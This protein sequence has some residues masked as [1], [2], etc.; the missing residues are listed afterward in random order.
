M[1]DFEINFEIK[2]WKAAVFVLIIVLLA[3]SHNYYTYYYNP[4]FSELSAALQSDDVMVM[5]KAL[6]ESGKFTMGKGHKLIPYI[7]PH[8]SDDRELPEE[9]KTEI[10]RDIQATPGSISG[11]DGALGNVQTVGFTAAMALQG[12]VIMD[13][14]R[15]RS[16]GGKARNQ[17]VDYV[18]NDIGVSGDEVAL[19]NGLWAVNQIRSDRLLSF[20]FLCLGKESESVKLA[21]L[22]GLFYF[23]DDRS[24][25]LFKWHPEEIINSAM[26]NNL[27][28]C[29]N[30]DSP[31]VRQSAV[32]VADKLAKAGLV[33]SKAE[34]IAN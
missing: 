26:I 9:L 13:L 5:G 33:L 2:G 28:L 24:K 25:G 7:L 8:L 23:I 22:A 31:A 20:W 17:I 14:E 32:Y 1:Q 27:V 34:K 19:K 16:V 29:L 12:L 30:D 21:A 3:F 4:R 15:K 10:I 6:Y 11:L 18:L